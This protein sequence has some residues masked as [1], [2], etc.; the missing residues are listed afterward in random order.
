MGGIEIVMRKPCI[1]HEEC[2]ETSVGILHRSS[3]EGQPKPNEKM[4]MICEGVLGKAKEELKKNGK[5]KCP[6]CGFEHKLEGKEI[7]PPMSYWY[8]ALKVEKTV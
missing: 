3:K 4:C 8:D 7:V 5:W 2:D 1:F 6:V